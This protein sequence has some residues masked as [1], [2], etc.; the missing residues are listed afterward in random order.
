MKRERST[1][2]TKDDDDDDNVWLLLPLELVSHVLRVTYPDYESDARHYY[3]LWALRLI[4][5]LHR[6]IIDDVMVNQSRTLPVY[7]MMKSDKLQALLSQKGRFPRLQKLSMLSPMKSDL[8]ATCLL[9]RAATL[10]I[11]SILC[12]PHISDSYLSGL[13]SLTSLRITTENADTIDAITGL[14][15]L[16]TLALDDRDTSVMSNAALNNMTGLTCLRLTKSLSALTRLQSL[17][18]YRSH[19]RLTDTDLASHTNLTELETGINTMTGCITRLPLLTSVTLFSCRDVTD[20]DL[21]RLTNLTQLTLI[22]DGRHISHQG[23]S[24]LTNLTRLGLCNCPRVTGKTLAGLPRLTE[25]SLGHTNVQSTRDDWTVIGP[26]IKVLILGLNAHDPIYPC[27]DQLSLFSRLVHLNMGIRHDVSDDDITSL[28]QLQQL[29]LQ[30]NT[31]ISDASVSRL[32]NLHT[33]NMGGNRRITQQS[34]RVLSALTSLVF[35]KSHRLDTDDHTG[36]YDIDTWRQHR[37]MRIDRGC[38]AD[39]LDEA[40]HLQGPS[41]SSLPPIISDTMLNMEC[42]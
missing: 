42:R 15:R 29:S 8:Y 6:Y 17:T 3:C 23:L 12:H 16:T 1:G 25:L 9:P 31:I 21:G 34:I 33:L 22:R 11:L 32:T 5:T 40:A 39:I 10:Q 36:Y 24:H 7:M 37:M 28:T 20:D 30:S 41:S 2:S 14:T 27:G 19:A 4:S 35:D 13:T 26:R 18:V 38:V